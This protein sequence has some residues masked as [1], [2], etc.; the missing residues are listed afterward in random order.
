VTSKKGGEMNQHT[1]ALPKKSAVDTR[2]ERDLPAWAYLLILLAGIWA[3]VS[4]ETSDWNT[5]RVLDGTG[6]IEHDHDT[7]VWIKGEWLAGEYRVCQMPLVPGQPLPDSAHLLC[8][9]RHVEMDE[10]AWPPDFIDSISEIEFVEL[11]DGK[12]SPLEHYF[13]VL[14]VSYWGRIDRSDRTMFSWR[15]QNK[16]SGL[17]CKALN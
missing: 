8:A 12:W 3:I 2:H 1:S 5:H 10:D 11:I 15:C 14:P 4:L 17:E 9:Q 6:W 13:H 7:P 16:T